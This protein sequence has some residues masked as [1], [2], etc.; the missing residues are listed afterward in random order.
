[1]R[2]HELQEVSTERLILRPLRVSMANELWFV[3]RDEEVMRYWETLPHED[4]GVTA[5]MIEGLM[6]QPEAHWWGIVRREKQDVIGMVGYLGNVGVP[7]MG[8]ILGRQFWGQGLGREAVQRAV[9]YGFEMLG[10]ARIE[11]WIHELNV[12]SLGLARRVGFLRRGQ[13]NMRYGHDE[14]PHRK[15]VYGLSAERWYGQAEEIGCYGLEPVLTVGD[16]GET[17]VFYRDQLGFHIELLYGE[18]PVHAVVAWANWSTGGARIQLTA[19]EMGEGEKGVA[20]YMHI[21]GDLA[22]HYERFVAKGV[23]V[24][25]PLQRYP[26]G[27]QE[28]DILDCNGYILRFGAVI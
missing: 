13:L 20:L 7:G 11:L 8:Y 12:A 15:W 26:W 19:G 4:E 25:R 18:P 16:V 27:R 22:A 5:E 10:L 9:G 14:G 6:A 2:K 3:F 23:V 21:D 24:Q 17:A 1:M 28:F